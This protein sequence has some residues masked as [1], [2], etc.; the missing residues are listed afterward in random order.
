MLEL[1][2]AQDRILALARSLG[3]ERLTLAEAQDRFVFEPL[4]AG[5][6]LPLFDNSA[7]DGYAVRS[8]DIGL[9]S[10]ENPI[11]LKLAGRIAAGEPPAASVSKGTCVRVFTGSPLPSGADAVV[12]QE[13]TE[14]EGGLGGTLKV[15]ECVR[16]WENIRF[17]GEDL[18]MGSC[19]A[20]QGDLVTSGRIALLAAV[21]C[22]EVV[23]GR[24]PVVGIIATGS[25]LRAAGELPGPGQIYESNRSG[26]AALVRK[27]GAKARVFPIVRDAPA[28]IKEALAIAA[29]ECDT[30]VTAGGV[31]VG[32]FDFVKAAFAEL[33]GELDFWRVAIKPGKPFALG[34]WGG[35]LLFGLP[36]NPVSAFV[37]FLMLVRPALLK[38]QG[39][40]EIF[41]PVRHAIL[42]EP[43]TNR[44]DRRHFVRVH[45]DARGRA[46]SAGTQ[47]SHILASLS[48]AN[49][50][51]NLASG[52]T[53]ES[54]DWVPVAFWD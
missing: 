24:Q 12:M 18:K 10:R 4:F 53:M 23:V 46:R 42:T 3:S 7:M 27:A 50:L 15:L 17:A 47:S 16:P 37:T 43:L 1:E 45:V 2:T 40:R 32:E 52:A 35:K 34:R 11:L 36:G 25:E 5:V 9:A 41:L 22:A 19:V 14:M 38:M 54:G 30:V 13:D 33:G 44:G 31:S 21:G 49:G 48:L 6:P 26:L 29:N 28:E 39:A 20:E 8:E 51:V